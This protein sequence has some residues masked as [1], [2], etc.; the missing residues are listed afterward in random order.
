MLK[1]SSVEAPALE[2]VCVEHLQSPLSFLPSPT[3]DFSYGTFWFTL[4][5]SHAALL[6]T[7]NLTMG[8]PSLLVT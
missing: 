2:A 1:P 8:T 5:L 4:S 7:G 6:V 3:F